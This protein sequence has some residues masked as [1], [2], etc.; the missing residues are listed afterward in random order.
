MAHNIDLN[1]LAGIFILEDLTTEELDLFAT[2]L[3]Q[4]KFKE[5][6]T[7]VSE[8]DEGYTMYLFKEGRVQVVN[9]ITLRVG[10]KDWSDAEK[11]ILNAGP[12]EMSFFGEMSLLTGAPRSATIK[13][14]TPC[15]LYELHRDDF[16]N[17][18]VEHPEM[19]FKVLWKVA[20]VL[21]NR[22]NNNN[23]DIKKLT[24]AL[25][26]ALSKKKK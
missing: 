5:G 26:I 2:I 15:V 19:G 23:K 8:G 3:K 18:A 20:A 24:T 16:Q 14:I 6:E 21:S 13:A 4:R 1:F 9:H 22:I 25:S 7:I 11:A 12:A 10:S 17:L